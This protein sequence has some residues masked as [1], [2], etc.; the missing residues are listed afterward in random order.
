MNRLEPEAC[1]IPPDERQR[2]RDECARVIWNP[3]WAQYRLHWIARRLE[4]DGHLA[5]P[6]TADEE[7]SGEYVKQLHEAQRGKYTK[8][9]HSAHLGDAVWSDYWWYHG[10]S[11]GLKQQDYLMPSKFTGNSR[12]KTRDGNHCDEVFV[13]RKWSVA[14]YY[15]HQARSGGIYQCAPEGK[16]RPEVRELRALMV[17]SEVSGYMPLTTLQMCLL[18][19][20]FTCEKAKVIGSYYPQPD[21]YE[22]DAKGQHGGYGY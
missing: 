2:L 13:T 1:L 10:G 9:E 4:R 20:G 12:R 17:V 21:T 6:M 14:N 8:L 16:I 11:L 18:V 19:E 3:R 22:D 7:P 5:L 15:A